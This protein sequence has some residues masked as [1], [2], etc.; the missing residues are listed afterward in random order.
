MGGTSGIYVFWGLLAIQVLGLASAWA[1]RMSIGSEP[2]SLS[3]HVLGLPRTCGGYGRCDAK[4]RFRVLDGFQCDPGGDDP[5]GDLQFSLCGS[6]SFALTACPNH[7]ATPALR[8][9]PPPYDRDSPQNRKNCSFRHNRQT[10][11]YIQGIQAHDS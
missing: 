7:S 11:T 10:E 4:C 8:R 3:T 1:A 2:K 9:R 5:Y 6:G